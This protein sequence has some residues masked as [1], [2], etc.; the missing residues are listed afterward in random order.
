VRWIYDNLTSSD[1]YLLVFENA[2]HNIVG[3]EAPAAAFGSFSEIERWD[4]PVWRKDRIRAIDDHFIVAFLDR[5][6]RRDKSMDSYLNPTVPHSSDGTWPRQQGQ[7]AG[8]IYAGHDPAS[9]NYWKGFQRRWALGLELQH[10][11]P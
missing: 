11:K 9:A 4:E 6:L 7:P 5:Y 3:A 2:R 10:D 8:N 1:R